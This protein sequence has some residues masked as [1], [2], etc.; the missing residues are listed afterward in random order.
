[1]LLALRVSSI[2]G[3]TPSLVVEELR[4]GSPSRQQ[5]PTEERTHTC[6]HAT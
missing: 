3:V 5:A 6:R 1:M 2:V 4:R